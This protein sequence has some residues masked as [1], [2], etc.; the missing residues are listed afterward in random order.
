MKR[1]DVILYVYKE[2]GGKI[3]MFSLATLDRAALLAWPKAGRPPG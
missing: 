1:K 3:S 2:S